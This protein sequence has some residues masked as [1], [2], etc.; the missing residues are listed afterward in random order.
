MADVGLTH[1]RV[2]AFLKVVLPLA[3]LALLSTLFLF[4]RNV[5]PTANI[6]F[7]QLELEERARDQQ[8]TAPYIAGKNKRGDLVA[9]TA[10]TAK[11]D[12][13]NAARI[14]VNKLD[15]RIDLI[16]GQQVTFSSEDGL[17]DNAEQ[18]A[19]LMGGVLILT[20]TGYSVRTDSLTAS[21]AELKANADSKIEATGPPGDF[22]AGA[23]RLGPDPETGEPHLFFTNGVKL[24]YTPKG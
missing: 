22:T 11:P 13:D 8:I 16:G 14:F 9:L 15:A 6:P 21:L 20:S 2:V 10:S 5:E 19:S 3:A 7:A 4:A 24:V 23:M 17:V 18:Q 1:S 12:P